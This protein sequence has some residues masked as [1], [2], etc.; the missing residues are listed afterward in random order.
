MS[1]LFLKFEKSECPETFFGHFLARLARL[2]AIVGGLVLLVIVMI[3]FVSIIGRVL[4]SKPLIGDFE[5]VE[6]GCATAI[7]MFMPLC[8]LKNGNVIVDFFTLHLSAR[9]KLLIDSINTLLFFLVASFFAW[10]MIYG[11]LD[12][13]K[14]QEQTM[15]LQLPV[16]VPFIPAIFSFALLSLIC[17]HG[18]V[19]NFKVFFTRSNG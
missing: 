9:V 13:I 18:S 8:Q 3:N 10:R 16:W 6:M 12:M 4:F 2:M 19:N 1:K 7:F 11:A 15:L 5:L 14:Y 17:V